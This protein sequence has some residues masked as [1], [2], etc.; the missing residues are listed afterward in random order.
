MFT[1]S[2]DVHTQCSPNKACLEERL[3]G[4]V[5]TRHKMAASS[6][7]KFSQFVVNFL[8]SEFGE[9]V[10]KLKEIDAVLNKHENIS[11]SIESKVKYL[12]YTR[13]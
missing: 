13:T 8:D 10:E 9:D 1:L 7:E 11:K 4:P 3:R 2:L 6:E 12:I 5:D